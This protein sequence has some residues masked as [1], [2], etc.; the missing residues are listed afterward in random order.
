[1][2]GL[3]D[4]QSGQRTGVQGLWVA[5]AAGR[6][7]R[8]ASKSAEVVAQATPAPDIHCPY[9]D[10]RNPAGAT[11]CIQCGGDL[12]KA[13]ARQS[14]EVLGGLG[15]AAPK[16]VAC[17]ACGTEN[18]ADRQFCQNCGAPLPRA[19]AKPQPAPQTAPKFPLGCLIAGG[20]LALLLV[21]GL[22]FLFMSGGQTTEVVGRVVDTQWERRITILG[23]APTTRVAWFDQIPQDATVGRCT[24]DVRE[25]VDSPVPGSREVCGTPYAVDQGTGFA[26]VVQDCQYEVIDRRCEYTVNEWRQV[27]VVVAQGAGPAAE[28]P[29]LNLIA[30]QREGD[31][32]ERYLCR[33]SANDALYVYQAG[34]YDEF[35]Q[36]ESDSTWNLV[37]NESG[38]VLQATP[39][40]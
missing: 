19:A 15:D 22:A 16:A 37:V 5:P 12:T 7:I 26:E 20:V 32:E 39:I 11:V 29:A 23:L 35:R 6:E 25:V 21:V 13:T 28:W 8:D 24:E 31:R 38:R 17:T 14:G 1:M 2:S 27:D 34:S 9:C 10:A 36:C 4:A 40:D 30:K 3:S 33:F 18:P